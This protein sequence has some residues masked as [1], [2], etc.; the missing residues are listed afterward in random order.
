MKHH[1]AGTFQTWPCKQ[2]QRLFFIEEEPN[3]VTFLPNSV[4][5]S[6]RVARSHF[7]MTYPVTITCIADTP[8]WSLLTCILS[9]SLAAERSMRRHGERNTHTHT[10]PQE[11]GV[12]Q[13]LDP[14]NFSEPFRGATE[15]EPRPPATAHHLC[16][17]SDWQR[18]SLLPL[19]THPLTQTN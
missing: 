12:T 15:P 8:H 3:T 7:T 11:D 2:G 17:C 6:K 4:H 19:L 9:T 1:V 10:V 5:S 18:L 14:A 13:L 16:G